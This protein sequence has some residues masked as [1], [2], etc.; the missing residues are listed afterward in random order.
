MPF[1]HGGGL[2]VF[3]GAAFLEPLGQTAIENGHIVD[4]G[5]DNVRAYHWDHTIAT[6]YDD[7]THKCVRDQGS[8]NQIEVGMTSY[9][10]A[11]DKLSAASGL[12]LLGASGPICFTPHG[13]RASGV[14]ASWH[15]EVTGVDE[16]KF[17]SVPI[18]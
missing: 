5:F 9:T 18:L 6:P 8:A 7:V 1:L 16:P 13:D 17:I 15:L 12:V 4:I 14:Y 11:K 3:R 10:P 2:A